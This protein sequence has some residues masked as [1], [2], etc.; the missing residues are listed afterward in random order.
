MPCDPP[1]RILRGLL[2]RGQWTFP[3]VTGVINVPTLRPDGSILDSPGY[4]PDTGL[5]LQ[6]DER[7][8]LPPIPTNPS[9]EE[10]TAALDVLRD[11]VD[12]VSIR[13]AVGPR[14]GAGGN[15]DGGMPRR[16]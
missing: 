2:E 16:V 13:S 10:A 8:I 4:D 1:E 14:G 12:G 9:L 5:W 3:R 11:T 15:A 7:I 6:P